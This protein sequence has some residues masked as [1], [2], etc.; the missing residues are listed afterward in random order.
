[1]RKEGGG[2]FSEEKLGKRITIEMQI[3]KT[4]N[5]NVREK[6]QWTKCLFIG[7]VLYN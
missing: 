2:R 4:P 7:K 6:K 1:V 3:K 5:K